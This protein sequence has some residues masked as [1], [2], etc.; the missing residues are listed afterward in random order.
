MFLAV[1]LVFHLDPIPALGP[2]P[3]PVFQTET[4]L[5]DTKTPLISSSVL[6]E[7]ILSVS[8]HRQVG[9]IHPSFCRVSDLNPG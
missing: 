3:L 4:Q 9:L 8:G 2:L 6:A 1:S 7:A 5:T